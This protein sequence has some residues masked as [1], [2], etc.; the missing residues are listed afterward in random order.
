[1]ACFQKVVR[2][3]CVPECPEISH[4]FP[5][6]RERFPVDAVSPTSDEWI[7]FESDRASPDGRY[8]AF[9]MRP[10]GSGLRQLTDVSL[11]ANHPVFSPDGKLLAFSASQ[12]GWPATARG[13]AVIDVPD[14]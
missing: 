5:R 1:M 2:D 6:N 12:P 3:F 10:D 9:V 4:S 7:A 8:A 14:L 11:D 13:I